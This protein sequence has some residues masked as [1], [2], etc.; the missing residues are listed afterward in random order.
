MKFSLFKDNMETSIYYNY[1]T[2]VGKYR[3]VTQSGF[4]TKIHDSIFLFTD[5]LVKPLVRCLWLL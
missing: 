3:K 1:A 4:K 5:L 2:P